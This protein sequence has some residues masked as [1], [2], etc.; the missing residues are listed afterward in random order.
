MAKKRTV[1][2]RRKPPD[3]EA[4]VVSVQGDLFQLAAQTPVTPAPREVALGLAIQMKYGDTLSFTDGG[5][6]QVVSADGVVKDI[7]RERTPVGISIAVSNYL[8]N[9]RNLEAAVLRQV[10]DILLTTLDGYVE[11]GTSLTHSDF[12]RLVDNAVITI[13]CQQLID[14]AYNLYSPDS[15]EVRERNASDPLHV[16]QLQSIGLDNLVE[17]VLPAISS[18][19]RADENLHIW[20]KNGLVTES[21]YTALTKELTSKY[22]EIRSRVENDKGDKLPPNHQNRVPEANRGQ[23]VYYRCRDINDLLLNGHEPPTGFIKGVL[24]SLA[25]DEKDCRVFWHPYGEKLFFPNRRP[26]EEVFDGS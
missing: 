23:D 6:M 17:N 21:G 12:I 7:A 14:F 20:L 2:P 1:I 19:M 5:I 9:T 25:N 18:L 8:K 13:T 26:E 3:A 4:H 22:L 11:S 15:L 16:R 24:E 10:V